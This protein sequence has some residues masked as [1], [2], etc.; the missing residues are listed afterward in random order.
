MRS[1]KTCDLFAALRVVK[2]VGIKDEMKR[3]ALAVQGDKVSKMTQTEAGLELIMGVLANCGT[4]SAEKAFY[5]FLSGVMEIPQEE[6]KNMDLEVFSKKV[7]EL[8]ETIDLDHWKG[9][10][11]S[12]VRLTERQK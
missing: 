3:L 10:F 4:E 5:D 12:L 7:I 9:F 2:E 6:L 11:L 8:V 1:L